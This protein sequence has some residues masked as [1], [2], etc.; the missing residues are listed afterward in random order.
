MTRLRRE[1]ETGSPMGPDQMQALSEVLGEI[2][3]L[4][5]S[6][7]PTPQAGDSIR[8]KLR[9]A[10]TQFEQSH[11]NLTYAVGAVADALSKLGI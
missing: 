10:E 9:E 1:I 8:V 5:D 7:T 4:L 3:S 2:E 6:E 11:P